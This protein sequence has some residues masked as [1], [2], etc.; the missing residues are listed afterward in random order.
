VPK[1]QRST[2]GNKTKTLRSKSSGMVRRAY[3]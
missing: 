3:W 2:F 1:I